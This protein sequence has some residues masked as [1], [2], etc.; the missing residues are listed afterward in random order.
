MIENTQRD[1]NIALINELAL[2]FQSAAASTL[3]RYSKAAGTKWNFLPIQARARLGG[4]CI[5]VDPYYLTHKA[6]ATGYHPEL[7][8]SGTPTQQ[9]H[10]FVRRRPNTGFDGKE[11]HTC[12]TDPES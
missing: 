5:G 10:G 1:V 9:Q 6:E 7:I 2:V 4:H 8:L 12:S 11:T 3:A